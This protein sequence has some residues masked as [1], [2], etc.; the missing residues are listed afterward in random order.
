M[1]SYNHPSERWGSDAPSLPCMGVTPPLPLPLRVPTPDAVPTP[2]A[3]TEASS[4][5][6]RRPTAA[7]IGLRF[8]GKQSLSRPM[9]LV[10]RV[11]GRHGPP[12]VVRGRGVHRIVQLA[13]QRCSSDESTSCSAAPTA[14]KAGSSAA[15]NVDLSPSQKH[16]LLSTSHAST[17][18][19]SHGLQDRRPH[20]QRAQAAARHLQ[21]GHQG[22]RHGLCLGRRAHGRRDGQAD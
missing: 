2:S 21:P 12:A 7:Q 16:I 9:T 5:P 11:D 6:G 4:G 17:S 19:R 22:Q 14:S 3:C 18:R 1:Y 8:A 13:L 10:V 15:T 20:R